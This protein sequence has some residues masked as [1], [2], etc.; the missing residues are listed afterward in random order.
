MLIGKTFKNDLTIDYSVPILFPVPS[1][2][3]FDIGFFNLCTL[4][5][6]YSNHMKNIL[7]CLKFINR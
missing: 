4:N 7:H 5:I 1:N 3:R 2:F 6:K